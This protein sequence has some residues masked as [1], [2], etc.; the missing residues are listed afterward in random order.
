M[1]FCKRQEIGTY[2]LT[3]RAARLLALAA[4]L[5][6]LTFFFGGRIYATTGTPTRLGRRIPI[7]QD[8]RFSIARAQYSHDRGSISRWTRLVRYQPCSMC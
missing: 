5:A 4:I 8:R 6:A 7:R 1:Q 2:R 3:L